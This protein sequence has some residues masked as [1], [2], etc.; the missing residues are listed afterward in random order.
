MQAASLRLHM[1][2]DELSEHCD[3]HAP[4]EPTR[5]VETPA[6]ARV[7]EHAVS[8]FTFLK[9]VVALRSKTVRSID[10]SDYELVKWFSDLPQTN[11][12]YCVMADDPSSPA[13]TSE[14]WVEIRKPQARP[15]PPIPPTL[16]PWL[17]EIEVADSS[18]PYPE[19][20]EEAMVPASA[21]SSF[22]VDG[23]GLSRVTLESC[24]EILEEWEAYAEKSWQPWA[25]ADREIRGVQDLYHDL[26]SAY[27][28]LQTRSEDYELLVGFGLLSW[29]TSAGSVI[30]RHLVTTRCELAFD[31]ARGRI[32]LGPSPDGLLL[33]LEQDMLD[34][35]EQPKPADANDVRLSLA[36]MSEAFWHDD[37]LHRVLQKWVH[38]VSA[39]G[40]YEAR[41]SRPEPA[42]DNPVVSWAPAVL[43]RKRTDRPILDMYDRILALLENGGEVP[44]GVAALVSMEE[45][46]PGLPD[47]WHA[48]ALPPAVGEVYFPLEANDE[49]HRIVERLAASPGLLVQGPPGTG[50]SHTIANLVAHLLADGQRVLVTSQTPRALQVLKNKMPPEISDLCVLLLGD[51]RAALNDLE[52]SVQAITDRY[53][54]WDYEENEQLIIRLEKELDHVRRDEAELGRE[55]VHLREGEVEPCTAVASAY[56]GTLQAIAERLAAERARFDWL[57]VSEAAGIAESPPL[58]ASEAARLLILERRPHD[59]GATQ[60]GDL[61]AAADVPLPAEVEEMVSRETRARAAICTAP[62]YS[63]EVLAAAAEAPVSALSEAMAQMEAFERARH[64]CLSCGEGWCESAARQ[65]L[66]GSSNT[67]TELESHT[68][69]ALA[70]IDALPADARSATTTG[71]EG[72]DVM[73][74]RADAEA[75]LTHLRANGSLGGRWL[76]PKVVKERLYLLEN[77]RIDGQEPSTAEALTKLT[78]WCDLQITLDRLLTSWASFAPVPEGAEYV[79]IAAYR[80]RLAILTDVVGL[81]SQLAAAKQSLSTIPGLVEPQWQS[82]ESVADARRLLSAAMSR[83]ELDEASAA[84]VVLREK[85][86]GTSGRPHEIVTEL[87]RALEEQDIVGYAT[88]RDGLILAQARHEEEDELEDVEKRLGSLAPAVL[89]SLRRTAN[90]PVWDERLSHLDEAWAWQAAM[91]WLGQA[92]Q[93]G[94]LETLLTALERAGGK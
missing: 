64:S 90:D 4:P 87:V 86:Q 41:G 26:F 59:P 23:T 74:V 5:S 1:K 12:C 28:K 16:R 10:D 65:V 55:L 66:G 38:S 89:E 72:R 22:E 44:P 75:L 50:K 67:W 45:S 56:S 15:H 52:G 60:T 33:T 21:G 83:K 6:A 31:S 46:V 81:V 17:D 94:A 51:D 58:T 32:A 80:D 13:R 40:E 84:I 14:N 48:T 37:T 82:P 69:Q 19:L 49:Q 68:E 36:D 53:N 47:A 85:L 77:V 79:R 42:T 62:P 70:T 57:E 93:P 35:E 30:K 63:D 71:L 11:G 2:D 29:R 25:E 92:T 18:R 20:R 24:P 73:V 78:Q 27:Q 9:E 43:L 88:A 61:P 8:L 39:D 3:Q 34:L 54:S 76:R 91:R 7:R